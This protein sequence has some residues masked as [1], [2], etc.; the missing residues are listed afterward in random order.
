[1]E[2][3]GRLLERIPLEN[4]L[5]ISF[6]DQSRPIAGDRYLVQLLIDIP[7]PLDGSILQALPTSGI[8]AEAFLAHFGS[9]LHYRMT[10]T[11]HFVSKQDVDS[12][13]SNLQQEFTSAG[14]DYLRHP[15]FGR[16]YAIK[17]YEDWAEKERCRRAHTEAVMASEATKT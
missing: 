6:Y 10:K 11:R 12:V 9:T 15:A 16:R 13:L 1:M 2:R 3:Q 17:T 7:I 14:L 8:S 4:G 5:Q